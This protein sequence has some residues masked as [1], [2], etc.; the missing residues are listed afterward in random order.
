[1]ASTCSKAFAAFIEAFS[2]YLEVNGRR[3]LS[4]AS[5]TGQ[6][7]VKISLRALRRVHDPSTGFPLI[8]DVVKV[9]TACDPS[10]LH[11]A[12]LEIKEVN[13]E[14]FIIVPTNLLSELIRRDREGLVNLL[15]GD[16]S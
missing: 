9:I 11:R 7:E 6:K 2:R 13:G 15:L 4:I 12:G 14:V 3:T 5:A 10:R 1:L 16:P 8:S